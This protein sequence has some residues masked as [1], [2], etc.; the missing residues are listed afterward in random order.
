MADR[1]KIQAR[2][3]AERALRGGRAREALELYKGL[4][5][6]K[7]EG[8]R[9][10]RWLDGAASAYVALGRTREAGYALMG[11]RR[12]AEAQRYLPVTEY[13][14]D[15]ALCASR[16]GRH[17]EAARTL[18][19]AGHPAL[20]AI[21]LE[22]AGAGAAARLE[23]ERV[24]RD[25]RLADRPYETALAHFNLGEA[26]LRID[27]RAA[28]MR[29]LI[30][31]GRMLE[32]VADDFETRGEHERA[33][34][35]WGVLLRLGK[36]VGSFENVAEGYLNAIRVLADDP[37]RA[38]QYYDDF[39][40]Y[41][42]EQQEWYAAAT[43]ARDA[44]EHSLKAGLPY[45]RHY[46]ERAA[47][48]WAETARANR[49][50]D[51]PIE[52][53]VN[54]LHAAIDAATAAGDL[55]RCGRLYG[56]LAALPLPEA[57]RQR[58]LAL[59]E[60]NDEPAAAQPPAPS[61]PSHLRRTDAYLDIWRQDLVEWELDGD[62]AAVLA[63]LAV[64]SEQTVIA[65]PALRALLVCAE[66]GF[67]P[68]SV[69]GAATLAAQL[70][71]VQAYE[72]LRP[73]ERLYE[74]PAEEV[75]AA[76]MRAMAKIWCPRSF[77]LIR[78]GLADSGPGVGDEALKTLREMGFLDGLRS[79]VQIFRESPSERVRLAAIESIARVEAPGAVLVLLE[80]VRQ[81][82]GA[83]RAAAEERL[84]N[85]VGEWVPTLLR[86]ARDIEVGDR[87]DTLDR[88]LRRVS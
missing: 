41:A 57:R 44:A 80:A 75:R 32:A 27:E 25:R 68:T 87:K 36:D 58:Y 30:T 45:D 82:S 79:L 11:L 28:G 48:L 15:W 69:Q 62:P 35:C 5:R 3:D 22:A 1:D 19:D 31:A 71:T 17:G 67:S 51:G 56:E 84:S 40:Q 64:G 50:A 73:L 61:F 26:L 12:F 76:V 47:E 52:L 59:A 10:E 88:I 42:V 81:E 7:G 66:P 74:H 83:I 29:E 21:E 53:T 34:D 2:V 54:A 46:L 37:T 23:W 72:V 38:A 43:L 78:A 86:Q 14:L 85:A 55:A 33:F 77:N 9:Y 20:A 60:R 6:E 4:L 63:R 65:R 16:L 18:S 49:V 8:R 13:P 70:G 39:L 24:V